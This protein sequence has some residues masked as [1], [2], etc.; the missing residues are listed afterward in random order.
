M[1]SHNIQEYMHIGAMNWH[2]VRLPDLTVV[3]G[4][5]G[6]ATAVRE[7]QSNIT[8]ADLKVTY[9]AAEKLWGI[10]DQLDKLPANDKVPPNLIGEIRS[11]AQAIE[12]TLVAE[13]VGRVV[14]VVTEKRIDVDKLVNKPAALLAQGVWLSLPRVTNQCRK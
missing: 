10:L 4:Q 9:R 1:E 14:F 12:K 5:N 8:K 7:F 6:A 11:E 13:S 3:G 2:L